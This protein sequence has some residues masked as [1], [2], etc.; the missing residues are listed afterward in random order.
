MPSASHDLFRDHIPHN[1]SLPCF[2]YRLLFILLEVSPSSFSV[3]ALQ[4]TPTQ[5]I[6]YVYTHTGSPSL[7]KMGPTFILPW[8]DNALGATL[9]SWSNSDSSICYTKPRSDDYM[10]SMLFSRATLPQ[11]SHG[12]QARLSQIPYFPLACASVALQLLHHT[13]SAPTLCG[14]VREDYCRKCSNLCGSDV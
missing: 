1:V 10:L 14:R 9:A 12:H 11:P 6:P 5:G 4:L 8:L 2:I 7:S 13:L 3:S